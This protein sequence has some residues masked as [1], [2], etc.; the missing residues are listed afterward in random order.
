MKLTQLNPGSCRTYLMVSEKNKEAILVDPLLDRVEDYLML[1]DKDRLRLSHVIDTHTHADHLS[2]GSL[3]ATH[4]GAPYVMHHSASQPCVTQKI[5]DGDL[6]RVSDTTIK[7]LHT[8][9]HTHDSLT[10]VVD[11]NILTGD[12]LFI[13]GAGAGRTD[14]PTGSAGEHFDSL[15]KLIRMPDGQ[16]IHPG[17]E[18]HGNNFSTMGEERKKNPTLRFVSKAEYLKWIASMP[19]QPAPWMLE[20]IRANQNCNNDLSSVQIPA[21][22]AACEVQAIGDNIVD[23]TNVTAEEVQLKIQNKANLVVIDVRGQADYSGEF[24]HIKDS[25]RV[26]LSDLPNKIE[27]IKRMNKAEVVTVC[28][29]G[30]KSKSAAEIL[31]QAGLKNVSSM[32]GGMRRWKELKYP[33]K[34]D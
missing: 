19:L 18:Y 25:I 30:A 12:F 7:F 20:V 10:L 13:G 1:I 8:P 31:K 9:G 28:N 5:K 34:Q 2:G 29:V 4:F 22:Q 15:Q 33:S 6:L 17:H 27:E 24:G 16:I 11:K 14:L 21:D 32:T 26:E 23:S 3:L